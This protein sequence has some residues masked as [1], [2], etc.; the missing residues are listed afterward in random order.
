MLSS[1]P[2]EAKLDG[3]CSSRR[4]LGTFPPLPGRNYTAAYDGRGGPARVTRSRSWAFIPAAMPGYVRKPRPGYKSNIIHRA[5]S[6]RLSC[7][8]LCILPYLYSDLTGS[9]LS[10]SI[11]PHAR[12]FLL[13][14]GDR[15]AFQGYPE[16][17]APLKGY[18]NHFGE[19]LAPSCKHRPEV[20]YTLPVTTIPRPRPD[21][22]ALS[23]P[24]EGLGDLP[25]QKS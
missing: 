6:L 24:K 13:R 17:A 21:S 14:Y 8:V 11:Y 7:R 20:A 19:S 15:A 25:T 3:G 16:G 2:A 1:T 10:N 12:A 23:K 18:F 4:N 22:S 9:V 5:S